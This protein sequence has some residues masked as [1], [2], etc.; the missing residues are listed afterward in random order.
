MTGV[1]QV[2]MA[3]QNIREASSQNM[4]ATRQVEQA[5]RELDGLS[6]RLTELVVAERSPRPRARGGACRGVTR[7]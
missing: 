1:D 3:M 2:A 6:K 5:A 4:A 7:S